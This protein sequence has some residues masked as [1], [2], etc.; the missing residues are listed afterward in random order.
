MSHNQ[1]FSYWKRSITLH[2]TSCIYILTF[3]KISCFQ[4]WRFNRGITWMR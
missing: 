2:K 1:S 4:P 3:L